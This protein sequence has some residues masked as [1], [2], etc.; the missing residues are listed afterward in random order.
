MVDVPLA[1]KGKVQ[2]FSYQT[3]IGI[4][5]RATLERLTR[6][7]SVHLHGIWSWFSMY[8]LMQIFKKN[9]SLVMVMEEDVV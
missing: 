9:N 2:S 8:K 6:H 4:V 5:S 1:P 3:N 7:A